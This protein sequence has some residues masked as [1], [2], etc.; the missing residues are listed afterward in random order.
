MNEFVL[1][2]F[3]FC[4]ELKAGRSLCFIYVRAWMIPFCTLFNTIFTKKF[5]YA[6]KSLIFPKYIYFMKNTSYNMSYMGVNL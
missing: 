4:G 5:S 2:A 3:F 6:Y 1:Q